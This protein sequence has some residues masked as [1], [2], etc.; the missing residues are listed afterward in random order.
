MALHAKVYPSDVPIPRPYDMQAPVI[1][2]AAEYR[3]ICERL[4]AGGLWDDT[5]PP[6]I[7]YYVAVQRALNRAGVHREG[8][9]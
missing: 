3:A 7:R 4:R 8:G 1:S 6:G 9:Q 2:S 5:L